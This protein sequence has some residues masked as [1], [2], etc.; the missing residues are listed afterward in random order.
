[1]KKKL[2]S[3]FIGIL[4]ILL[5]IA[6]FLYINNI[7]DEMKGGYLIISIMILGCGIGIQFK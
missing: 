5:G 6:S 2:L 4:L 7:P 1:M 3:I